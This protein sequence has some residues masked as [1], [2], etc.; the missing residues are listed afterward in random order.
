VWR[1]GRHIGEQ[2]AAA[3]TWDDEASEA[4]YARALREGAA[5][6]NLSVSSKFEE[7]RRKTWNEYLEFLGKVGRGLS[8]KLQP[9]WM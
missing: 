4:V 6:A 2:L 3:E 7:S 5:I 9:T 8:V 1:K